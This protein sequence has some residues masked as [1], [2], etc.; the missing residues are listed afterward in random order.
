MSKKV[1]VTGG[2]RGI[3]RAIVESFAAAGNQVVFNYNS[4]SAAADEIVAAIVA[5]GGKAWA[6]KADVSDFN[7]A[8]EFGKQA[9]EVL[10]G[11]CDVLVNNAGITRDRNLFLMSKEEWDSVLSV[12][13]DGYFN[14]TRALITPM[15]KAKKG[16]IVNVASVSGLIGLAG[17]TNYCAS[18]HGIIGLTKALAKEAAR[19]KVTVNAVAPGFI[20]TDMTEKLGAEHIDEVRKQIPLRRFGTPKEVADLVSFLASDNARYITGQVFT[21]DCGMTA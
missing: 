11:E 8:A 21:I 10:G 5:N 3:G 14:V 18:K 2:S 20:D 12:N 9:L 1:I 15:L 17:Q 16:S 6:F 4:S 19:A 13:L 7:S